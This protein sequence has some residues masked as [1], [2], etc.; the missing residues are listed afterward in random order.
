MFFEE[1]SDYKV[2]LAQG[3]S[4]LRHTE[5]KKFFCLKDDQT[6]KDRMRFIRQQETNPNQK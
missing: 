1:E 2:D 6:F 3:Y 4:I 5:S